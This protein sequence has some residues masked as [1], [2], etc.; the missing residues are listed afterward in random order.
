MNCGLF[1]PYFFVEENCFNPDL[2][3]FVTL[4]T[5][6]TTIILLHYYITL[7]FLLFAPL[8]KQ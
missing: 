7:L 3:L 8:F 6:T 1:P 4:T 5:T 2:V